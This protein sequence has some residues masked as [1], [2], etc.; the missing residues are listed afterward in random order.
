MITPSLAPEGVDLK[1]LRPG[2]L[3]DVETKSHCYHIECLGGD[4]VRISGHPEFCPEPVRAHLGGVIE[5]G[6]PLR[7]LLNDYRPVTTTQVVSLHVDQSMYA[8]SK[9][10]VRN[11][12]GLGKDERA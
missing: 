10:S 11:S 3:I 12:V 6:R 5:R 1:D 4:A 9:S 8:R 7:F 2:S